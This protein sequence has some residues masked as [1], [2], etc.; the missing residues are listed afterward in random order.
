MKRFVFVAALVVAILAA[1]AV[2]ALAAPNVP[3]RF[4]GMMGQDG[5]GDYGMMGDA[6]HMGGYGM[7]GG[8]Y[9]SG[10]LMSDDLEE[11]LGIDHAEIH[12]AHVAGKSLVE[13]AAEKGVTQAELI[14]TLLDGRKAALQQAVADGRLTQDAA[15]QMLKFMETNIQTM[16]EAKGMSG[17]MGGAGHMGGVQRGQAGGC[18]GAQNPTQGVEL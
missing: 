4:L 12:A 10:P 11:L 17:M 2:A 5:P 13:I 16:V 7:M 1:G 6:G 15:D 8:G 3:G 18:H 9:M 14:Q